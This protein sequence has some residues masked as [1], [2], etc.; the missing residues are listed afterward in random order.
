MSKIE[1]VSTGGMT[2]DAINFGGAGQVDG[3]T[4]YKGPSIDEQI[5]LIELQEK[6]LSLQLK[7]AELDAKVLEKQE[8]EYHIRDLR[9]RLAD[10][11]LEEKQALE[12]RAQQ[13]RTFAQLDAI[14]KFNWAT[15]T[16]RKGGIVSQR[17]MRVLTTGGNKEQFAVIKHQ[18]INGDI[19]VHCLRCKR[20]WNPPIESNYYFDE[21][22]RNVA[23]VDGKFD[24]AKFNKAAEDYMV[25][26]QFPTNN[27]MSGSVICQ[28]K[29][30]DPKTRRFFDA[31][32]K[33]RENIASTNLR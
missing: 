29:Q 2:S 17:D 22:G 26:V 32:D 21:N 1:N 18:M 30:F 33:Y 25:A 15:C 6:Q 14:D 24:G 19:W 7:Q 11:D 20:T 12:D 4:A 27:S 16:H 8:R 9:G 5:K 28:F 31:N 13:G 23:P 10:R 3:Q